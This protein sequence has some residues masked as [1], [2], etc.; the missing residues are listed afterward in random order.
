MPWR[1]RRGLA[2]GSFYRE[3]VEDG[4][5]EGSVPDEGSSDTDSK[6]T[7]AQLELVYNHGWERAFYCGYYRGRCRNY[8][9]RQQHRCRLCK[10]LCCK[11][12]CLARENGVCRH[13]R[14]AWPG[15]VEALEEKAENLKQKLL[16]SSLARA[17]A[18]ASAPAVESMPKPDRDNP[19]INWQ[20]CAPAVGF[21]GGNVSFGGSSSSSDNYTLP[22]HMHQRS[23][24]RSPA[25]NGVGTCPICLERPKNHCFVPCGHRV[26]LQ[27][28]LSC[29]PI[30]PQCRGTCTQTIRVWD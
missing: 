18:S 13:C 26:C 19:Y 21:V 22:H 8:S 29:L 24:S 4:Q 23:R 15:V 16:G 28:G 25:I 3:W 7:E 1:R 10:V 2:C 11:E 12:A 5:S 27:C 20:E 9:S 14:A 6:Y 17:R 30:C